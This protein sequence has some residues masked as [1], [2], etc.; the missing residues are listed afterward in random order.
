MILTPYHIQ[1]SIVSLLMAS[2]ISLW[3]NSA[4]AQVAPANNNI[5]ILAKSTVI[6]PPA[7]P[8]SSRANTVINQHSPLL[9]KELQQRGFSWG[10][11]VL[12]RIFKVPSI[13]EV[14]I[15]KG[16]NYSLFKSYNICRFSGRLGPK[17]REGDKQSPEG[18]YYITPKQLN[19]NSSY[20]LSF[21][22][23]YPNDYDRSHN[24]TGSALMV[25]GDCVSIGCYAMTNGR[26][27]EI[28]TL[29]HNAFTHG[30]TK[31]QVQAYPFALTSNNM[32]KM[33]YHQWYNFWN[34]LKVGY[35][36]FDR[37]RRPLNVNVQNGHYQF[38]PATI[39][40]LNNNFITNK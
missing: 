34:N 1:K 20:F 40:S 37:T 13:L 38:S 10:S 32:S 3:A 24:Y 22:L 16:N 36:A 14:W 5:K 31:I 4:S 9:Q 17:T 18:F 7:I 30:Q 33:R 21:N 25:H 23:G 19:P 27:S 15:K 28:Y 29:M 8:N 6:M 11:P 26:M 35:D 39:E 12:I 2:S